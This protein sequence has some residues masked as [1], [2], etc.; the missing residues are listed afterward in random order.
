[1]LKMVG[2]WRL[3]ACRDAVGMLMVGKM[4]MVDRSCLIEE[5]RGQKER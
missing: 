2:R 4:R 5:E 1:M 3:D